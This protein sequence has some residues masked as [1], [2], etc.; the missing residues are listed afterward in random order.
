VD[1][2]KLYYSV[3]QPALVDPAVSY[4]KGDTVSEAVDTYCP[5]G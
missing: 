5:A 1:G 2:Y 4:F 3:T